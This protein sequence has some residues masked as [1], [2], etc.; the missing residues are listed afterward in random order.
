MLQDLQK[1]AKPDHE[2]IVI[3]YDVLVIYRYEVVQA[4]EIEFHENEKTLRQSDA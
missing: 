1:N 2:S 4:E 3:Q